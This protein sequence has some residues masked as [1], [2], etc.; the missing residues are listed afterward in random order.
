[1]TRILIHLSE[2]E[3]TLAACERFSHPDLH[4]RR[5][6]LVLWSVQAGFTRL[7]AARVAWVGRAAVQRRLA[8]CR[9]GG[10]V[11]KRTAKVREQMLDL[12]QQR[13]EENKA[14][15][16]LSRF[17]PVWGMKTPQEQARLREIRLSGSMSRRWQRSRVR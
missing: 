14:S 9:D 12:C 13:L 2:A 1:M 6:M 3:Q 16:S 11:E 15:E 7:Q 5:R 4:V 8:A 17:D 10:Q